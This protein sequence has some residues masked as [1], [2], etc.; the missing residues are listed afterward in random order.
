MKTEEL[1]A[2]LPENEPFNTEMIKR[3]FLEKGLEITERNLKVRVSRL[4]AKGVIVN[5]S[6]GWYRR[7]G[8]KLFEPE[9][10][11][12]LKEISGR[13][14]KEFPFLHY[15]LWSSSWLNALATLQ[16]MRNVLVIEVEAGSEEA[17]FRAI[18]ED[19]PH[20]TFL[21][22][23]EP[24]WEKYKVDANENIII[25]TMISESPNALYHQIK[26]ARLEK[27][28][29]DLY[30]DKFWKAIFSSE[31]DNIYREA[32]GS[33]DLNLSTLLSYAARRG[34]RTEIWDYIKSLSALDTSTI[35]MIEK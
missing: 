34:R 10:N 5:V 11:P 9:L 14:K 23:S 25:K 32:C 26:V 31:T 35:E 30:C 12:F 2:L 1:K 6:R 4:K 19:F 20:I 16:L 27:I 29:V 33:Y 15:I 17:V 22:P 3:S 28:L 21:N 7:N 8:K 18:K 24:E 13:L